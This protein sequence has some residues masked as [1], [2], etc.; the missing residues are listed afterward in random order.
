MLG[1]Y[2]INSLIKQFNG[3]QILAIASYN[4]GPAAVNRWIKDYGDPREMKDIKD[5][6]N[7]MELIRY[8]ETRNYVQRIIENSI[9]YEY[10]LDKFNT[11]I[12]ESQK[13]T[14]KEEIEEKSK[15]DKNKK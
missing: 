1:S 5:I 8:S 12:L 7:W 13:N 9:V 3:S 15:D 2:Y 11:Q 4:A 10:V 6:V 14:S